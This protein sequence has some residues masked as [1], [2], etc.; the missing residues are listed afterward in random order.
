M[1]SKEKTI[2]VVDDEEHILELVRFNLEKSGY[3]VVTAETGSEA[4]ELLKQQPVDLLILDLMLPDVEGIDVCKQLRASDAHAALPIIM[5]TAKSEE[6]DRILG[7]ELGADDYLTKPFSVKE[8]VARVKTL[9][10]RTGQMTASGTQISWE[11]LVMDLNKHEVTVDQVSLEFTL[12]EF[13]L[14]RFLLGNRGRVLSRYYLLDEIWG[15]D[16]FGETRTV[17]VHIRNIRRKLSDAGVEDMIE[18]VRG[19][20]YKIR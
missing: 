11:N 13:E 1:N 19:I 18:T 16:Y 2:L 9:L 8:L 7:L 4:M 14:L 12:K 10:R 20:G 17:D 3:Q 6:L 5:L 15:Y